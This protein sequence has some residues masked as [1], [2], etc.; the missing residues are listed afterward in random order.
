MTCSMCG[1][2][3]ATAFRGTNILCEPCAERL[4]WL[5]ILDIVQGTSDA[6][7]PATV[8]TT[9]APEAVADPFA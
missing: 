2:S 6:I 4:D 8:L 7:P 5:A 3:G 1:G 9:T